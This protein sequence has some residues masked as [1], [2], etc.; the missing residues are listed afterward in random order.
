MNPFIEAVKN[1][2]SYKSDMIALAK[3]VCNAHQESDVWAGVRCL[4][5][6]SNINLGPYLN[7]RFFDDFVDSSYGHVVKLDE[8]RNHAWDFRFMTETGG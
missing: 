6:V 4:M 1:S 8:L 2:E 3:V 5:S 7:G